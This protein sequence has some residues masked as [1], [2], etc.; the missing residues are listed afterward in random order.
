MIIPVGVVFE[1]AD[2]AQLAGDVYQPSGTPRGG[3]VLVHGFSATRRLDA[4]VEHARALADAGFTVLAYDGRGHGMSGGECTL[5]QLEVHDVAAAVDLLRKDVPR[6]VTVGAS[7]GALAVLAHALG[8]PGLAGIVLVSIPTATWRSV[9]TARAA[10]AAVLTRTRAGR[11]YIRRSTGIRVSP[12][13]QR[14]ELP[15]LQVSRLRMPVAIVH[16]RRDTMIRSTAAMDIYR[17]A[18]E[19]RRLELVSGLAHAFQSESVA[20]VLRS[21]EWA[22][23]PSKHPPP[24]APGPP[25]RHR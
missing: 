8:D 17:A 20:A 2:G 5:G 13:W 1:T 11:A 16:G 23:E 14:G 19:P 22:F 6:L 12:D 24:Q 18:S 4:I 10:A 9:L 7:M 15:T 21:V 25:N 3:V